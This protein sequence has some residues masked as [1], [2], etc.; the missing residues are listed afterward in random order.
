VIA[1]RTALGRLTADLDTARE[2]S[3]NLTAQ[4]TQL[5]DAHR[6]ARVAA[7]L[8]CQW[9]GRPVTKP[10]WW[11]GRPQCPDPHQCERQRRAAGGAS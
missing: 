1:D 7:D 4:W 9:C 2:A 8:V 11:D 3:R 10:V 6:K 5:M